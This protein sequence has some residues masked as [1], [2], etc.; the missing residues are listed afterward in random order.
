MGLPQRLDG[1]TRRHLQANLAWMPLVTAYD[2]GD[3]GLVSD[4]LFHRIGNVRDLSVDFDV[5]SGGETSFSFASEATT[6]TYVSAGASVPA[7]E[8]LGSVHAEIRSHFGAAHSFYVHAPVV[9]SEAM[10]DVRDVARTLQGT[11]TWRKTYRV[12]HEVFRCERAILL[13]TVSDDTTVQLGAAADV[14]AALEVG[15]ITGDVAVRSDRELGLRLVG[16]SG[17]L[18][19]R[20]FKLSWWS[21][22]PVHLE[23]LADQE[24]PVDQWDDWS[25]PL[26]D[27]L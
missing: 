14:L 2:V 13:S 19:L 6:R 26:P 27:D 12:V 17:A 22:D 23:G 11:P 1:V 10:V 16:K 18:G 24:D 4:G 3:Y 9:R 20:L 7:L 8:G 5:R 15:R 21:P 25:V